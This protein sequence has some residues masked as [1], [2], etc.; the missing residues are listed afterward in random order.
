MIFPEGTRS[1]E[2]KMLEAKKGLLLVA[3]LS[4]ARIAPIGMW[5]TEN[6][7]PI[8]DK[9]MEHEEFCRARVDVRFG[10]PISFPAR[11]EGEDKKEYEKRAM[12][13]I[14]KSV[15]VL[16]PESYRGYYSDK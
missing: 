2:R 8:N 15:A 3:K 9:D 12:D 1:R 10:E 6:F 7:L 4:K 11:Q 14:M 16:I 5:G 13:E